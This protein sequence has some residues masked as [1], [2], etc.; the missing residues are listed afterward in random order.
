[1][2]NL[3]RVRKLRPH[4][5]GEYFLT[6]DNGQEL[7]L[8]GAIAI[9]SSYCCSA[10]AAPS[11]DKISTRASFGAVTSQVP[12]WPSFVKMI[13]IQ[14]VADALQ[15]ISYYHF[16]RLYCCD[17]AGIRDGAKHSRR[18][19]RLPRFSPI[20]A[21]APKAIGLICQD[22]G[23]VVAF[24]KIGMNARWDANLTVEEMVNEGVRRAVRTSPRIVC[25]HPSSPTRRQAQ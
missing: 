16:S 13:S 20:H 1:M 22:T 12:L 15:Y 4:S 17:G 3:S 6:L 21:C 23:I 18:G 2:V 11:P 7:K 25:V 5:N 14:S 10:A 9:R 19:M 8:S 24:V